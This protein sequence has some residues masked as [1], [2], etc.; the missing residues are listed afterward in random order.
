MAGKKLMEIAPEASFAKLPTDEKIMALHRGFLVSLFRGRRLT[1]E[2]SVLK[3]RVAELENVRR[4]KS[5]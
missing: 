4:K 2:I 1:Q 5:S 3:N